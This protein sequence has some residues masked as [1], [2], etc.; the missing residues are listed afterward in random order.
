MMFK[1]VCGSKKFFHFLVRPYEDNQDGGDWQGKILYMER[2]QE[3]KIQV[4]GEKI[5]E[6]EFKNNEKLSSVENK[7]E[8]LDTKINKIDSDVQKILEFILKK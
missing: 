6:F 4:L 1:R 5:T 7:I 3:K 2:K 8:N